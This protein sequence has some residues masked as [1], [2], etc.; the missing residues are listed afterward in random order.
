[1]NQEDKP[2]TSP[3]PGSHGADFFDRLIAGRA[4][5]DRDPGPDRAD[6]AGN[7]TLNGGG[8]PT[9]IEVPPYP[10][11]EA[12]PADP[13]NGEAEAPVEMPHEARRALVS[14]LRQGVILSS[15]K[16]RLFESLYR[17]QTAIRRHL[18]EVYLNLV[19]DERAGVAFVAGLQG[20]DEEENGDGGGG[21]D[22]GEEETVSLISR[23]TLSLYDTLLLLVLRKYY[24]DR[25]TAGEQRIVIDIERVE[26][27]LTPF[28][29]LT[30]S[31]KSDRRKLNAALRKMAD[32]KIL[33]PIR[34]SEDRFEITPVI[35]YVV[36]AEFLETM[37][38]EYLEIARKNGARIEG[39]EAADAE[40]ATGEEGGGGHRI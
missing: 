29:P 30:N 22:P 36:S 33:G 7:A 34:G 14:L 16:A 32:K 6:A 28:L 23:R 27:Y 19:L 8:E 5:P 10:D 37:L 21:E 11:T 25:E 24:Q 18:S 9:G 1:M 40:K 20:E 15:R 12:G 3:P 31:E 13:A 17:H 26:S 35:R 4:G 2:D 39:A 38:G